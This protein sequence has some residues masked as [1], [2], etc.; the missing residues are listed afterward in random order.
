MKILMFGRGVVSTQYAWAFEKS[1]HTVEFYVRPGRKAEYGS[2]VTLNVYDARKSIR[3]KLI[4]EVW[5]IKMIEDFNVHHDYDLIFVS[6]QH[7]HFKKAVEFLADKTGNATVVIFNNFWDEPL[8][9]TTTLPE[10]RLVWGFPMAGGGFDNK[11]VLNGTIFGNVTFGTFGTDPTERGVAVME[12]FKSA[13]FKSKVIKDFR[14]WLFGHFVM[15]AALHLETLKEGATLKEA[16][17]STKHW[18]N[19]IANGKELVPLL[20]ARN[21]DLKASPDLN[22]FRVPPWFMSFAMKIIIRFFP[23][24]K[25]ILTGH[26]NQEEI[27]SYCKDVMS[28]AK[29]MNI[30]LPRNEANKEFYL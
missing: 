13:G 24:I 22:M 15:N 7:Y 26:S 19:V 5:P 1:G 18:K 25:Q 16:M 20:K 3:G 6:V 4:E 30:S 2:T 12:L 17:Q 21:V 14:S 23:S 29:E 28:K 11:G 9:Q 8:E 10:D 27:K